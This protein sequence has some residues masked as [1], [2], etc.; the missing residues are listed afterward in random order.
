MFLGRLPALSWVLHVNIF[1]DRFCPRTRRCHPAPGTTGHLVFDFIMDS[2]RL[3]PES[4]VGENL[5]GLFLR[6][7]VRT[8]LTGV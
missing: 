4:I 8:K 3:V 1:M 2:W 5:L 6:A 7:T